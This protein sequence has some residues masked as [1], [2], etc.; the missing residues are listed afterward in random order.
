MSEKDGEIKAILVEDAHTTIVPR[1]LGTIIPTPGG[2]YD[3]CDMTI[4][5]TTTINIGTFASIDEF[6][7]AVRKAVNGKR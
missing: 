4:V 5:Q 3:T 1:D 6:V 2:K 7:A